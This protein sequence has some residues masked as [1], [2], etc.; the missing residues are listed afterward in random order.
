MYSKSRSMSYNEQI[1]DEATEW[2]VRFCEQ[3]ADE[4]S[5]KE[6]DSW[7]RSSPEHIRAYLEISAFWEAAG[8][9]TH[10]RKLDVDEIVRRARAD[11]NVIML[12]QRGNAPAGEVRNP[13]A[14]R[15]GFAIAASVLF[16]CLAWAAAL[17]WQN[18]RYPTYATRIGEQRTV[19]LSD[20]STVELNARTRIRIRFTQT[21][22][23]VDLIE[24]QA[25]FRVAK[26]PSRAFIVV[27]GTTRVRAVGTQFDIYRKP[28]GTVVT[29]VEGR[30]AVSASG[31]ASAA[32]AA[33]SKADAVLLAAG[34]QVT[35]T[36]LVLSAPTSADPAVS[37]AWTQG[38]LVFDS[39]ALSEVL[40]E[41]GRYNA[42]PL[43][44]DDPKLLTLH[45][46]GTFATTD[47]TQLVHFLAD[48]FGLVI[49]DTDDGVHL[50]HE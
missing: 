2:L 30:V 42:R 9:M 29:V 21:T 28:T 11:S 17:W 31:Q 44:I 35:V 16:C 34:E 14:R 49:H 39:T 6:F 32:P 47:S 45:I 12:D 36:P 41:F 33:T 3:E 13:V 25:L 18:T 50:A 10:T 4:S 37:T 20:G 19:I 23:S 43:F 26:S 7:L 24:G 40:Q 1:R 8:S 46:S 27:T 38:K 48:R 22:R 5:C 15:R